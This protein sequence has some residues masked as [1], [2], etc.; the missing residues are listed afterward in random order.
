LVTARDRLRPGYA[1]DILAALLTAE[2]SGEPKGET[3]ELVADSLF[4]T[5]VLDERWPVDLAKQVYD[6]A[7]AVI[8]E[9]AYC[10]ADQAHAAALAL[11]VKP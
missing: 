8:R 2:D 7:V 10:A 11:D 3:D 1:Y 6:G 9:A 4:R 5:L